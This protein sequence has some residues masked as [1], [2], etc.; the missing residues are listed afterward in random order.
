MKEKVLKSILSAGELFF[1]STVQFIVGLFLL[2]VLNSFG[3]GFLPVST[4]KLSLNW[5]D[6]LG[7]LIFIFQIVVIFEIVFA[8]SKFFKGVTKVYWTFR[9][10]GFASIIQSGQE[11][12]LK[13]KKNNKKDNE[14]DLSIE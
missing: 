7:V 3:I 6:L 2:F 5:N 8:L 1:M 10:E 12:I 11:K 9:I 14:Q 13:V 4:L